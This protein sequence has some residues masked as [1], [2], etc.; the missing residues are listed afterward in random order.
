[1][2]KVENEDL[3]ALLNAFGIPIEKKIYT[4]GDLRELKAGVNIF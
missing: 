3:E 1:M 4:R 2:L